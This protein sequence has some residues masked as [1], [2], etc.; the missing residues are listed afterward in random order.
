MIAT[1]QVINT[2]RNKYLTPYQ[3]ITGVAVLE[4]DPEIYAVSVFNPK[5]WEEGQNP[6]TNWLVY[7]HGLGIKA[8]VLKDGSHDFYKFVM[9]SPT[10]KRIDV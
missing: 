8:F 9:S 3:H 6:I 7:R 10:C 4:E 1:P 2:F 5:Y